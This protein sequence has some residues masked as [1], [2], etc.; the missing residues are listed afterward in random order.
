MPLPRLTTLVLVGLVVRAPQDPFVPVGHPD[1]PDEVIAARLAPGDAYK[2]HSSMLHLVVR[3]DHLPAFDGR[4]GPGETEV[5]LTAL[6]WA[7]RA[8]GRLYAGRSSAWPDEIEERLLERA[9]APFHPDPNYRYEPFEAAPGAPWPDSR[10]GFRV[11]LPSG[12][13]V[14]ALN[15]PAVPTAASGLSLMVHDPATG[16]CSPEPLT[17]TRR[18]SGESSDGPEAWLADLEGDGVAELAF[19]CT[20]H[21]GTDINGRGRVWL[22]VGDDLRLE[23]VR[24][25][26][27][28]E[29]YSV[30]SRG[31]EGIVRVRLVRCADGALREDAWFEN[32]AFGEGPRALPPNYAR[33]IREQ[34]AR[35]EPVMAVVPYVR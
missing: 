26:A 17:L 20:F 16:A 31:G 4:L 24:H 9:N 29:L 8:P 23:V 18:W 12:L 3:W 28:D 7:P 6:R 13:H 19:V 2:E 35:N 30:D 5:A 22:R 14:F 1:E 21:N 27:W 11:V 10:R 25:T 33:G 15:H 32:P 34:A